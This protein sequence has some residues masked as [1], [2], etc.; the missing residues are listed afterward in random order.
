M[1]GI[2]DQSG[3][4]FSRWQKVN[5]SISGIWVSEMIRS[6][7]AVSTFWTA[8]MPLTAVVTLKPAFFSDTSRT[9]ADFE[10][11]LIR[12]RWQIKKSD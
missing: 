10:S 11:P 6:G 2:C 5:P 3:F 1:N 8:S 9:R 12:D 4:S 7:A